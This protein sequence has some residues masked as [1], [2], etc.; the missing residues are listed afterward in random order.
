MMRRAVVTGGTRGIGLAIARRLV[1]DGFDVIAAAR[2]P[3]ELPQGVRHAALDVT[4]APAVR[5]FFAALGRLDVLVNSAGLAGAGDE[6]ALW[7][8]VLATN[9][10]GTWTCCAAALPMLPDRTGRIV[11]IASVLGLRGVADQPAYCAAKHGVIGLTRSLAMAAA[12]R[13]ITVNAVCPGWVETEMAAQ[14]FA[15]LGISAAD[16]AAGVPIGRI[17][18]AWEIADCVAFLAR[19]G[20]GSITGQALV[21]DG[22]TTVRA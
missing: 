1:A 15:E 10:T 20:A 22:G 12:S 7:Q 18:S 3:A 21:I 19:A 5:A 11:N 9:L 4:D 17:A 8:A 6:D 13:G 16:A 2:R 14:R